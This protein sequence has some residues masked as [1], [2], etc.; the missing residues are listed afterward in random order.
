VGRK[1]IETGSPESATGVPAASVLTFS[2][3]SPWGGRVPEV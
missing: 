2:T 3:A 1:A